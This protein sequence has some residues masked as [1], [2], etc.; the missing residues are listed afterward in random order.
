MSLIVKVVLAVAVVLI[1]AVALLRIRKLRRD[2]LR[3]L[4]R[5]I[6]RRLVTPPP[7]PYTPSKGFRLLDGPAD[8]ARRSD[9]ARPRLEAEREYVFSESQ[10]PT[11]DDVRPVALRHNETWALSRSTRRSVIPITGLGIVIVVVIVVLLVGAIGYFVQRGPTTTTTTTTSTTSTTTT[12]N[13]HTTTTLKLGAWRT[14]TATSV[15]S[16]AFDVARFRP[17]SATHE[18]RGSNDDFFAKRL[19]NPLGW[20]T[21]LS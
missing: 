18:I 21:T 15:Q 17:R 16:A 1:L 12:S 3:E 11:Y 20:H 14:S 10:M 7:S 8:L 19:T 4:S 2:E 13:P 6:D 5:P 9:P